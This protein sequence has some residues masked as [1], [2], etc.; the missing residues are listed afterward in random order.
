MK[1]KD[2]RLGKAVIEIRYQEAFKLP[3]SD[4]KYKIVDKMV[5][6]KY[7]N[8]NIEQPE[9][10]SFFNPE[11]EL[12][13][14]V[15]INRILIDWDQPSNL[16]EFVKMAIPDINFI[17]KEINVHQVD[18]VGFRNFYLAPFSSQQE[19]TDILFKNFISPKLKQPSFADTYFSP[20][21][22][23]SGKKGK[24]NFN[25]NLRYQQEQII[26]GSNT[27]L[28]QNTINDYLVTDF[29]CYQE[30]VKQ[31]K[32]ETFFTH[33][34]DMNNG[35]NEYINLAQKDDVYA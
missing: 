29:D 27:T 25:L 17:L 20:Q 7:P 21:V 15:G 9:N 33:S 3:T 18:R 35:L 16:S 2:M 28:L 31:T 32:L 13:F 12:Q 5:H 34:K 26:H 10:L 11:K 23:F 30:N 1:V 8:Y 4:V 14:H 22:G 19:V 6:K 24:L